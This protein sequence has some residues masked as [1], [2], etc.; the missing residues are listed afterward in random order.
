VSQSQIRR[1]ALRTGDYVTGQVRPPKDSERY[2][3]LLRVEAVNGLDPEVT[4]GRPYF[5][6]LTAI[7]PNRQFNLETTPD[8]LSARVINLIAPIDGAARMIVSPPKAGKTFLQSHC[9]T[10][11]RPIQ[12]RRPSHGASSSVSGRRKSPT[13]GARS[14]AR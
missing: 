5:E 8:K 4:K 7:F 9:L 12:Q 6:S 1:F 2:Y 14:T 3:G 10:A 13:C 11:L